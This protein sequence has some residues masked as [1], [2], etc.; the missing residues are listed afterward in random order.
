MLQSTCEHPHGLSLL[1]GPGL[2]G[3]TTVI[4]SF[5][6]TIAEK[7]A[8]AVIDGQQ[9]NS[10]K[11]LISTLRQ[12]GYTIET[13]SANEILGLI[14]VFALQQATSQHAPLLIIE[15][16]HQMYPSAFRTL[17]ELA[18]LQVRNAS[19][20]KI[21]LVS[22]RSLQSIVSSV[23][24]EP[25]TKRLLH[26]FQLGPMTAAESKHYVHAKLRAAGSKL[27]EFIF[28]TD[29]CNALF[30][31]S[32]GWPGVLDRVALL[33]IAR[34]TTLPVALHEI[35]LPA[36]ELPVHTDL[37]A[38]NDFQDQLGQPRPPQLIVTINGSVIRD[39]T[40][41]KSR[42]IIG[43]SEHND[44][45]IKSRFVSRHHAMLVRQ[46]AVTVLMDLNSTNGTF[47]NS[48]RISNHVLIHDDVITIGH[49]HVKFYDQYAT[50][51]GQLDSADFADTSIMKT[52]DDM[53]KLLAQENTALIETA[54]EDLPTIST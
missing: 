8:V 51:R 46:G 3:K 36:R 12:F 29:A 10:I 48:T 54:S 34:A 31:A 15:N 2:S 23:A 42:L 24:M 44:L 13:D 49:H 19:A 17:C 47:I 30:D 32:A 43:R 14:R 33:A 52:L 7:H 21:V 35:G 5:L 45:S 28:G 1:Q 39:L 25:I 9:L 41:N 38:P 22:D 11:L 18:E 27:P 37:D 53:R 6:E 26:D 4:R 40:M 20:I 16:A 50:S